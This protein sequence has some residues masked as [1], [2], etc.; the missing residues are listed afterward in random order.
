[1]NSDGRNIPVALDRAVR[2]YHV[3]LGVSVHNKIVYYSKLFHRTLLYDSKISVTSV[4]SPFKFASL[5]NWKYGV[6]A[7]L[8][9][10]GRESFLKIGWLIKKIY[11]I[12]I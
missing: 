12:Q 5:P 6:G 8:Y 3:V 9:V 7:L 1:V 2:N 4:V 10:N 11:K